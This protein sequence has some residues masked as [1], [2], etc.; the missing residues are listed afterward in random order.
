ME[1]IR[2]AASAMAASRGCELSLDLL[3]LALQRDPAILLGSPATADAHGDAALLTRLASGEA[4]AAMRR[5]AVA[6][7][8]LDSGMLGFFAQILNRQ[9][10]RDAL[11]VTDP[12][13]SGMAAR[14]SECVRRS[15]EILQPAEAVGLVSPVMAACFSDLLAHAGADGGT[16]WLLC[17]GS[18]A[19]EAVFNP[20]EPEI[21]GKRQPLAS[22]I[23]SLVLAT[24]EPACVSTAAAHSRHSPA[25]DIALGKTTQSMIAVPFVLAG[26]VRGVLSAVRF[27]TDKPFGE[28]D[29]RSIGHC[30][31]IL[32]SLMLQNLT[33]RIL[34]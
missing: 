3:Q 32:A 30:A 12:A 13:L 10:A 6:M 27:T 22:G 7:L 29:T 8:C 31:E 14:V 17:P 33:S 5:T 16:L 26:T 18:A 24:G 19:L 9:D 21:A 15:L 25:I 11:V 1:A 4:D 23:V 20:M 2:T 28:S 34:G